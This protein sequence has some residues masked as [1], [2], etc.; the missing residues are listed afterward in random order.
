MSRQDERKSDISNFTGKNSIPLI[1]EKKLRPTRTRT[2]EF[3]RRRQP[4]HLKAK[5]E[6]VW[7]L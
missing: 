1:T 6:R 4:C 2:P 5:S 7:K 3:K